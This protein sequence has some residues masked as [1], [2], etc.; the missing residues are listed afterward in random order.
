MKEN[1]KKYI[2]ISTFTAHFLE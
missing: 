1:R 2:Y